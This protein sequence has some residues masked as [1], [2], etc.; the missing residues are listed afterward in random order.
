[1]DKKQIQLSVPNLDIEIVESLRECIE[2]G[3]VST[4]GRFIGEFER[5]TAQYVGIADA[6]SAQSGTAGLHVALRILGISAGDEVL[7]PTLTFV[8]AVNPVKYLGAEPVFMDCDD[9]F[10]M[11]V[12]KLEQFCQEEC[13]FDGAKLIDKKTGKTIKAIVVVHIFGNLADMERIMDISQK[14]NLKVLEDATEALGSYYKEGRYRGYFSGT[15]ADMGVYSFNANKI[16]TTG[17]GG[18][19]VSRNQHYLD[20]ARY[21]TITAKKTSAEETLFFVHGDVGY[22]YRMLNLQAA[23]GVSQIDKLECFIETKIANYK[24]YK[25]ELQKVDGIRI[26]PF[27]EDI[28]ANHWFYSLY[29]D[30]ERFG[31]SRNELMHRLI[32]NGIQCRPVWKL[33]HTLE[34]YINAQNYKIAKAVDYADH[35]LNVPCSTNLTSEEI[36]YVCKIIKEK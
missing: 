21:L 20:E 34:P 11:D 12:D 33:I 28:R 13:I 10:C 7:V 9:S 22:N 5:K 19:I 23:L 18:M 4:G 29:I 36:K 32:Q 24:T 17:G 30:N 6:V 26:I 31:E 25:E 35:I 3:W 8:A 15:I 16:I 14:Y 1:M 27:K 2:T